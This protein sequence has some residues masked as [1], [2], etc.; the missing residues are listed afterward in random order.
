MNN[1]SRSSFRYLIILKY[2]IILNSQLSILNLFAQIN[3]PLRI[4]LECEKD[5]QDYKAVSL[6]DKGVAVFY[7]TAILNI[8][9]AQWIFIQYDTNL[10]RTNLHKLK[11]PNMCQYLAADFSNNK[12]YLFLQKPAYKKDSLKNYLLEWNLETQKFQLFNLQNYKQ[13]HIS[14]IKVKD[15]YLFITITDPKARSIIYY[16]LKTNTKRVMQFVE[17]EIIS[18]ESLCID[19]VLRKTYCCMFLKNKEGSR[20]ELF[21]TDY[22]GE[23][24]KRTALPYYQ[25]LVYNSTRIFLVGKDSLLLCGSYTNIKDKKI[26][27]SYTGI[28]TMLFVK[29]K[30]LDI[31]TCPFGTLFAN[32]SK[33]NSLLFSEPNLAMNTHI[34]HSNG[35]I[36]AITELFYPEYQYTVSSYRGYRYYGYEPPT[37]MFSG[38]RF[39]NASI[40]EFDAQGLLLNDWIFPINNVLTQ[41]LYNLVNLHQGKEGNTLI[42]YAYQ[43]DIVSQ[44]LYGKQVLSAQTAIPIELM[45]KTDILEYSSNLFMRHW[46]N[47]SFL[48]SGYQ[49][50]KNAR[51][52]KGKRYVFFLNKLICE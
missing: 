18:I 36:F 45:N 11:I 7:Q 14:S 1:F 15:D 28:Y 52:G 26:K 13:S 31:N 43:F 16:N 46:Y 33:L 4:E 10:V 44:F 51:Y 5:Q 17:D 34:T 30:M 32:D 35:H 50:I 49:Y 42:Y 25:D 48:L 29:N 47:N 22:S 41:S 23:I 2:I 21:V 27:D 9:T 12:L 8:D 37:Q 24:M 20:A 39:T 19:T 40:F 3:P 6:A 38:F